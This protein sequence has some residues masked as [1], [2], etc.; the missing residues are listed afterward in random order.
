MPADPIAS[1][2]TTRGLLRLAL[3]FAAVSGLGYF[4]HFINRLFLSWWS[5]EAL[6][7]AMPAGFLAWTVQGF[8][9]MSAGYLGAFAGQHHGAG[10]PREAGAMA[11]PM[12]AIAALAGACSLA[13]IP[14]RHALVGMFGT[15]PAVA[16]A[17]AE[18]FAWYMA[19]TG[20]I[21]LSAGLTGFFGG[22]GR[23]GIVLVVSLASCALSIVLNHWLIFGG[24]GVP[25][26]GITGAGLATLLASLATAATWLALL[27][28]PGMRREFA[29]WSGR[30]CDPRR[31]WR[32]ASY[33][34]PRGATEVL[35]M[36]GFLVFNG[37]VSHLGTQPLAAHNLVFSIYLMVMVPLL[38]LLNGVTVAVGQAVGA[39]R[40]PVAEAVI[41]RGAWIT[42]GV[43]AAAG[44][45]FGLAPD[46]VLSPYVA[47]DP[48]DPA[49]AA[50]WRG[51]LDLA[52]PLMWL[53]A[54]AMLADVIQ[55][56]FRCG[57]QGAGDTRWPLVVLTVCALLLM[58]LPA[59]A[60]SAVQQAGTWPA[61]AGSPLHWC[62][63]VFTG[64]VWVVAGVMW[65]R[66]RH[67]PWRA[68]SLREEKEEGG[69]RKEE[70]R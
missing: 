62:W 24:L 13:L 45:A 38:G 11:W 26:L 49:S 14:C 35:E 64:Y 50:R 29:T 27:F 5:T 32:F 9:I 37:A 44:L 55:F 52:R 34:M 19:E 12:M 68:M 18:L 56:A 63:A 30:N 40:I 46:L 41:R 60:I 20:L 43:A 48:A 67:G 51:L 3:P 25:A 8:F 31:L 2:A 28:A 59:A 57:V 42:A 39:G 4:L 61:W 22:I 15:E 1:L 47:V 36:L 33:A 65:L 69:R 16:A 58:G 53:A 54:A 7:A 70:G 10:E 66:W 17:M 21:T 23:P 6:A